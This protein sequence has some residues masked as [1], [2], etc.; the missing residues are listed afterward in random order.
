MKR[1]LLRLMK[2]RGYSS[3]T[4]AVGAKNPL[5]KAAAGGKCPVDH[6]SMTKK[7]DESGGAAEKKKRWWLLWLM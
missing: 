5:P 3:I 6:G 7:N 1:D 4:E 2:E